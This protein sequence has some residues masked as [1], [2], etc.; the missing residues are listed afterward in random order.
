[1]FTRIGAVAVIKKDGQVEGLGGW[2]RSREDEGQRPF[3]ANGKE[4]S[5]TAASEQTQKQERRRIRK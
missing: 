5:Q 2:S 1:M 4:I 3:E